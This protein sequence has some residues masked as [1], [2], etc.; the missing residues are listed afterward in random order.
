MVPKHNPLENTLAAAITMAAGGKMQFGIASEMDGTIHTG[1]VGQMEQ[2]GHWYKP[3][4]TLFQE[5]TQIAE[6]F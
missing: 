6:E 2:L 1:V 3:R 4:R 5:A